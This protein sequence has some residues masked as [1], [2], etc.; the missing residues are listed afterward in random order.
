MTRAGLGRGFTLIELL[1]VLVILGVLA[2]IVGVRM[3]NQVGFSKTTAAVTD[4]SN[5]ETALEAF[6]ANCGRYPTQNEGLAAL[7]ETPNISGWLGPYVKF[8][9]DDPWGNSYVYQA[10]GTHFPESY[11][12]YS[13]GADSTSGNADDV[14]NWKK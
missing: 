8:I 1:V 3:G 10:P 4:L 11:D 2:G 5:L 13:H 6:Q 12:L 7:V 9:P 14:V